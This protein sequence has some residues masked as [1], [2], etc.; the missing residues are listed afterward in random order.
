M[1]FNLFDGDNAAVH[2]SHEDIPTNRSGNRPFQEIYTA[3]MSRRTVLRGGLAA[4]VATVFAP[5]VFARGTSSNVGGLCNFTPVSI[6]DYQLLSDGGRMLVIS[7]EYEYQTLIPWGTPIKP[8]VPE[9]TGDPN[10]RPTA[11]EQENQIW[12]SRPEPPL[13]QRTHT[14]PYVNLHTFTPTVS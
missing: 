10:T 12:K 7:P 4:A 11:A 1:T 8:G 14:H 5:P 2:D 6:E 3:S 13:P 9:Y